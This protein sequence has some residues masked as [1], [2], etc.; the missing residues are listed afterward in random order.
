MKK[1]V[2]I[3]KKYT[4]LKEI[5]AEENYLNLSLDSLDF[6]QICLEIENKLNGVISFYDFIRYPTIKDLAN[7]LD[8]KNHTEKIV[9]IRKGTGVPL[10]IVF[11]FSCDI[12]AYRE[13]LANIDPKY[14]NHRNCR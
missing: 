13:L 9:E 11:D 8:K 4:N 1:I 2:K 12:I 14:T 7:Y 3:L 10:V 5:N 6:I